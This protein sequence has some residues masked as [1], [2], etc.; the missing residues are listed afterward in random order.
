MRSATLTYRMKEYD[1]FHK[2]SSI[3]PNTILLLNK[4][5]YRM[6]KNKVVYNEEYQ[7]ITQVLCVSGNRVG[8]ILQE[9]KQAPE[10]KKHRMEHMLTLFFAVTH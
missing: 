6:E 1:V 8:G 5:I 3:E 10:K 9:P 4:N 2:P 7:Y